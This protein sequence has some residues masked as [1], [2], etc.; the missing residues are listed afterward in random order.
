M[1]TGRT[2]AE[3]A[4]VATRVCC[5]ELLR[6]V[7]AR[8]RPAGV[9]PRTPAFHS[10]IAS[11]TLPRVL[12]RVLSHVSPPPS[13]P[14]LTIEIPRT[15]VAAARLHCCEEQH[16][17]SGSERPWQQLVGVPA[18]SIIAQGCR[19]GGIQMSS[20]SQGVVGR[21][22]S[23]SVEVMAQALLG[24]SPCREQQGTLCR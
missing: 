19:S 3:E 22:P 5:R 23:A 17:N 7:D 4:G 15:G 14:C 1:P 6:A 18:T 20:R 10:A 8:D 16:G 2:S 13:A 12:P 24:L 21:Y 9:N 11:R